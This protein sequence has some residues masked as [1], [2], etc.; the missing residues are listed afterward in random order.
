MVFNATFNNITVISWRSEYPEETT[1]LP[2]VT[3]KLYY[4][5]LYRV[6]LTM[7]RVRTHKF[8]GDRQDTDCTGSHKSNYHMITTT[9]APGSSWSLLLRKMIGVCIHIVHVIRSCKKKCNPCYTNISGS[10]TLY[11]DFKMRL[12]SE[13][14]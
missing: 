4:I 6:H 14:E 13:F 5:L 8:S 1:D 2:Q 10:I 12:D 7:N 9:V 11:F 3:N